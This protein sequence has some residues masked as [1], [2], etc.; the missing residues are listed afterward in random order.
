M[1]GSLYCDETDVVRVP[2]DIKI[3]NCLYLQECHELERL[4][5]NL[6]V[7]GDLFLWGCTKLKKLPS[8]LVVDGEFNVRDCHE[9]R[10]LPND[11]KLNGPIYVRGSGLEHMMVYEDREYL[12]E[13]VYHEDRYAMSYERLTYDEALRFWGT[14]TDNSRDYIEAIERHRATVTSS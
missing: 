4:P 7:R 6:H 1:G 9:L 10:S 3:G 2:E 13:I 14:A 8:G 11:V 12:F 5:D